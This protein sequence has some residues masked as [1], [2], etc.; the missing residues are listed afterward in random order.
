MI[1]YYD[2][3]ISFYSIPKYKPYVKIIVKYNIPIKYSYYKLSNNYILLPSMPTEPPKFIIK[4]V[5]INNIE[6]PP[7]LET[8]LY[9]KNNNDI[10]P[11]PGL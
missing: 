5:P 8:L 7:G 11:P 10:E 6:P 3:K 1:S 9:S 2:N 4:F